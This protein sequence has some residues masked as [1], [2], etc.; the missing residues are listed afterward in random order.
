MTAKRVTS[1]KGEQLPTAG[2]LRLLHVL[3]QM[4]E[5]TVEEI[6][7]AHP[8]RSRPNY[9]TTQTLLRIMEEK[10]FITHKNRGRVFVFMPLVSRDT[11][12][13]RSVRTL[14]SQNFGGS[15][16]GLLLNLLEAAPVKEEE[17]D[18]LEAQIRA[19][20]KRSDSNGR[21]RT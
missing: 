14:L 6:V 10:R 17:L 15:A 21:V 8:S 9:K 20:R 5:A 13:R 12:D 16:T 2:E 4:G 7:S 1:A 11:V 18:E 19:Y 3:W